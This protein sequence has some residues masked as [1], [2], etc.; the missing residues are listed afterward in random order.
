MEYYSS[1]E[2]EVLLPFVTI[3]IDREGIMP[4]EISQT[5]KYKYVFHLHVE[6]FLKKPKK[7]IKRTGQ[8]LTEMVVRV[9]GGDW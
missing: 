2:N 7:L 3:W 4:I 1:I 8:L 6:A 5:E 9:R